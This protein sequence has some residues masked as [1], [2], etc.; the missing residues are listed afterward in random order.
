MTISRRTFVG[1][2][3]GA[4]SLAAMRARAAA[5]APPKSPV[6]WPTKTIRGNAEGIGKDRPLKGAVVLGMTHS[7]PLPAVAPQ[8][9]GDARPL[10]FAAAAWALALAAWSLF[11]YRARAL[12]AAGRVLRPVMDALHAVHSGIVTDYVVWLIVG[13]VAFGVALA[14][15]I[16]A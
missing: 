16:G 13:V 8:P 11:G 15:T 12:W 2:L 7:G 10:G 5:L 14:A 3:A 6:L 4:A 9:L 1:S